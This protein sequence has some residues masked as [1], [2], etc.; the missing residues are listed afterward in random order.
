MGLSQVKES[1]LHHEHVSRGQGALP[2]S[3]GLAGVTEPP[4]MDTFLWMVEGDAVADDAPAAAAAAA[5]LYVHT[6]VR[7]GTGGVLSLDVCV[8]WDSVGEQLSRPICESWIDRNKTPE[9]DT[10]HRFD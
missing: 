7:V 3:S 5:I 1:A 2:M 6:C 4:R 8:C 10:P 9:I